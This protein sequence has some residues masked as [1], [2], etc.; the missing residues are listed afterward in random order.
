M[1]R[2]TITSKGQITLPKAVR[3]AL[4]VS[5]GDQVSFLIREDGTVLVEAASVDLLGLKG[6]VK[7][8]VRGVTVENMKDAVRRSVARR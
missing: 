2:S 4:D 3:D 1:P 8:S 7:S 5:S 6:S